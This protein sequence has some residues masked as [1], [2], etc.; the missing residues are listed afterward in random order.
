[1]K[2]FLSH[3]DPDK[4]LVEAVRKSLSELGEEAWID[5]RELVGGDI[6]D[7]EIR[8]AIEQSGAFLLF[9]TPDAL[10]SD[11]VTRELKIALEVQ[12]RRGKVAFPIVPLTVDDAKLGAFKAFFPGEPLYVSLRSGAGGVEE[13]LPKIR[14]ALGQA[15]PSVAT[16]GDGVAPLPP[17]EEL[18][19]LLSQLTFE[20]ERPHAVAKLI[21]S[22]ADRQMSKVE[23]ALFPF[24]API[25]AI[26]LDDLRWYLEDYARWPG[27]FVE[28]RVQQVETDL[29]EWGKA[30]YREVLAV[31]EV[32]E[33]LL[34]WS[35]AEGGA[36]RRFSVQIDDRVLRG[37]PAERRLQAQE[38][39]TRLLALPWELLHNDKGFLFQG[40][41]PIRVRRRLPTTTRQDAMRLSLPIR[42]LL[43]CARPDD[44]ACA[45]L[46]HRASAE[47]LVQATEKLPGLVTLTV[48]EPATF[49]AMLQELKRA[50]DAHTP[51]HVVH[52]DGHGVYSKES[53]LGGLCFESPQDAEK[54]V[55]R[56][57]ETIYTDRLSADLRGFRIP[58]IFLDA[59][60]GAQGDKA[61]GSVA[62]ALL[63]AGIGSVVAMT[64]S[65][66]VPTTA[67][68]V[69][70]FYKALAEGSRVG[71]AMLAGQR[72][73]AEDAFRSDTFTGPLRLQDWFV[74]VLYQEEYDP[75]LFTRTIPTRAL[76][77]EEARR[78]PA[79]EPC[80]PNPLPA[81]S[82]AARSF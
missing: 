20:G 5:A 67:R 21:H 56:G 60:Q 12:D 46:D 75:Q 77:E 35:Q 15:L 62:S 44:D 80:L 59:C 26:E 31:D 57:H 53:G 8:Q 19:L 32:E 79:R 61:S 63:Q 40:A 68:F 71:E 1:M 41:K 13:A 10:Q 82:G 2:V 74:P 50:S 25:E 55:K 65:V 49:P 45:Y 14:E 7:T 78:P 72:Y 17:I 36:A 64:H 39:G 34:G 24:R 52:F 18:V 27:G 22:P 58:L 69:E 16:G 11:W 28:K 48:L 70:A 29:A 4:P 38:V 47:P 30:L 3:A 6:L 37:E 51:Y 81:S 54:L 76:E 43:V 9:V 73:L 66:L 23:S 42:I 33:V